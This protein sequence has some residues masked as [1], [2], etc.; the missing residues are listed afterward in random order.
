MVSTVRHEKSHSPIAVFNDLHYLIEV[1]ITVAF[2]FEEL[3]RTRYSI[4]VLWVLRTTG[5]REYNP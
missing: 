3:H 5:K 1:E 2:G 4:V